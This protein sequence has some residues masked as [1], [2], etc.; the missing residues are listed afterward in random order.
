M[1]SDNPKTDPDAPFFQALLTPYRSLGPGGFRVLM[2]IIAGTCLVNGLMFLSMGAWPVFAF[3]GIDVLVVWLAFRWNYMAARAFEE[4]IVSRTQVL[5]RQVSAQ[6]RE[7]H[8]SFNPFWTRLHLAEEE[9]EGVVRITLSARGQ[10]VV[11]GAFLNPADRTSFAGAFGKALATAR[12]G[13]PPFGELSPT[14]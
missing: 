4:V 9:D 1:T 10:S 5:V 3:L 11:V 8:Y 14:G 6:G 7:R 2:L 12:A 13:G